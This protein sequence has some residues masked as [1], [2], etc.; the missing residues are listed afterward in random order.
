MEADAPVS[1]VG[2]KRRRRV[3]GRKSPKKPPK[4]DVHDED[5]KPTHNARK[6]LSLGGQGWMDVDATPS[7][8]AVCFYWTR[9]VLL[10]A[11][12]GCVTHTMLWLVSIGLAETSALG[13]D[14]L[15]T[16]LFDAPLLFVLA[17]AAIV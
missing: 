10:V 4:T 3:S 7:T 14:P 2:P 12:F 16:V 15:H 5:E 6:R 17:Y 11:F 8:G 1:R 9:R 13:S